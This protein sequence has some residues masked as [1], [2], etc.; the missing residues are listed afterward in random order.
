MNKKNLVSVFITL[1]ALDLFVGFV[2]GV[3]VGWP[4][5]QIRQHIVV[6]V[7]LLSSN[8]WLK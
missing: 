2:L 3:F 5:Q 7:F 1:A 4:A 6:D 8:A